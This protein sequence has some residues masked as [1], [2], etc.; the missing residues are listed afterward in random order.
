MTSYPYIHGLIC[1]CCVTIQGAKTNFSLV[2]EAIHHIAAIQ[3]GFGSVPLPG[4]WVLGTV[5]IAL[6]WV[7]RWYI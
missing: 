4:A 5:G 3:L 6:L 7:K 1:D 2:T